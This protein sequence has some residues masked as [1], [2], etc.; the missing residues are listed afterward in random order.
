MA[1]ELDYSITEGG[2]LTRLVHTESHRN[3]PI[4][5]GIAW[6]PLL[7]LS[8]LKGSA[9]GTN[10]TIPFL[11]DYE[12]YG[13]LLAAIPI[14]LLAENFVEN[15]TRNVLRQF[16]TSRLISEKDLPSF[17]DTVRET[18]KINS[19]TL[20]E[21]VILG[22]V[23]LSSTDRIYQS[24][25]DSLTTWF[26]AGKGITPAGWY[27]VLISLPIFQFLLFRWL[28]RI[29]LW[30]RLLRKISR[31]DLELVPI[32]PDKMGGLGFLGL[33][34]IPF[35]L[36][37]LAGGSVVAAYLSN[38]IAYRGSS[39]NASI[40]P[41]VVY[42]VLAVLVNLIPAMVFSRKLVDL[43]AK[44]ILTY[45]VLGQEYVTM[46]HQ[47]WV[48]GNNPKGDIILGSSDIQS[49]ADLRN[50]FDIVQNMNITP[51]D[52]K[53]VIIAAVLAVS[54]ALLLL[55]IFLPIDKIVL[56]LLGISGQ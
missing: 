16:V 36:I 33:S 55:L 37:S 14:L 19:S 45:G 48:K 21:L 38:N 52:R 51:I 30:A 20:P 2:L 1:E 10:V 25:S 22:L 28:W 27:Y 15:R 32:H 56:R 9:I 8:A 3:I 50:S 47:K 24:L 29:C 39:L 43:R 34:Q 17:S 6:L 26:N 13:R 11:S 5:M 35:G 42:A 12:I 49:L 40:T 18:A 46:F 31:L 41:M 23:Y 53:T 44:G 54:P 4:L 7:F